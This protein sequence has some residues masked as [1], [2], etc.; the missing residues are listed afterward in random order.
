ME[1]QAIGLN[2]R[3]VSTAVVHGAVVNVLRWSLPRLVSSQQS[4]T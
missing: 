2:K 1:D 4:L 3:P